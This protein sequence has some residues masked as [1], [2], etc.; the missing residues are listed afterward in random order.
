MQQRLKAQC[1][2]RIKQRVA[3]SN[4]EAHRMKFLIIFVGSLTVSLAAVAVAGD[5]Q[6]SSAAVQPAARATSSAHRSTSGSGQVRSTIRASSNLART[7]P[8]LARPVRRAPFP[9]ST[10]DAFRNRA[11][12]QTLGF[13]QQQQRNVAKTGDGNFERPINNRLNYFDALRRRDQEQHDCNWWRKHFT[14]IV[15]VNTGFYYWD[16][17]YWYPA[18]GYSPAYNYYDYDGPIYTYGNLLPDQVVVNVQ[19]ALQEEGYYV[20]PING[21]LGPATRAA[22]ASYQRDHGLVVTAAVDQATVESL[23]L[24]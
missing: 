23:G 3:R 19:S 5:P 10:Q 12:R 16:A 13:A 9:I 21:S 8:S 7:S 17:G 14:I 6:S 24:E 15:F 4:L 11:P 22:L 1:K 18:W 20:G 2:S